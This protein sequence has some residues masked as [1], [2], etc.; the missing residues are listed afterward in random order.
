MDRAD[1]I[2][3]AGLALFGLLMIFV[4]IPL[5]T[6]EGA[7]FGLSPTLFPTL[8]STLLT[9]CALGQVAQ[10]LVRMRSKRA[11]RPIP[12]SGWNLLMFIVAGSLALGGVLL[13]DWF[14]ILIG[15]P[16][17]IA[18][19]MIFLGEM[20]PMRVVLTA[21]LPVGVVYLLAIHVLG[22]ALP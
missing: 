11:A 5:G 13:V 16:A 21:T 22:T 17:L 6:E 7:Y 18:I 15:G 3:G 9:V 1:L 14:G 12:V 10:S 19:L 2:G 8:L 20:N 4:L